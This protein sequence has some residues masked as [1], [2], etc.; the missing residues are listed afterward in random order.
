MRR[1][2]QQYSQSWGNIPIVNRPINLDT[3][4]Y[5]RTIEN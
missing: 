3:G 4:L 5:P 2:P 1:Y